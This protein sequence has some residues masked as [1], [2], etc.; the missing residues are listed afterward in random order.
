MVQASWRVIHHQKDLLQTT[1]ILSRSSIFRDQTMLAVE[2]VSRP[3]GHTPCA[4]ADIKYLL[5]AT[6]FRKLDA[7][8]TKLSSS[9]QLQERMWRARLER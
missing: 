4:F 7:G 9:G 2:S 3:G 6:K 1:I 5:R 8:Q